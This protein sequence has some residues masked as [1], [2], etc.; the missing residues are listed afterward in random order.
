MR[1]PPNHRVEP[2]LDRSLPSL[3][4]PSVAVKYGL[5]KPLANASPAVKL[6]KVTDSHHHREGFDA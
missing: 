6:V 1:A 2:T 5:P 3:P 4:L